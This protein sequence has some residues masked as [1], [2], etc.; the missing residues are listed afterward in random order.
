MARQ[1]SE[2]L[3]MDTARINQAT[4]WSMASDQTTVAQ[5]MY[6]M[7]TTDLRQDIARIQQ[8]TLVLG[9]WAAYKDYGSTKESTKALFE[10]QYTKLPQHHVEMSEAGKHFL[11]WD[12]T[13]WFFAQA[14]AFLK[15]NS[16]AKK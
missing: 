4:R 6:D 5:A 11:M 15:Q 8:P 10:Q 12:D 16:V 1:M 7:N 9:S 2:H 13:Q 3:I 14:D